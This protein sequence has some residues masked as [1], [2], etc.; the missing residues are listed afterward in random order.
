MC[1]KVHVLVGMPEADRPLGGPRPAWK[2]NIRRDHE[3]AGGEY[4]DWCLLA[5]DRVE[6]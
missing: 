6:W 4:V 3:E 5:L 1:I 2:D